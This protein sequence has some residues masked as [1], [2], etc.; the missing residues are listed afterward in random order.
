[1]TVCEE[2][3]KV[4][5][6]KLSRL[7][8]VPM[9]V[10][11]SQSLSQF[12][13]N[14]VS[15]SEVLDPS[16]SLLH[17]PEDI[18]FE[19]PVKNFLHSAK[20]GLPFLQLVCDWS[21]VKRRIER[22]ELTPTGATAR[23][24]T[25]DLV[26]DVNQELVLNDGCLDDD[27]CHLALP[28]T[29]LRKGSLTNVDFRINDERAPLLNQEESGRVAYQGLQTLASDILQPTD[30]KLRQ[31]RMA[32]W[33]IVFSENKPPLPNERVDESALAHDVDRSAEEHRHRLFSAIALIA[34]R[35]RAADPRDPS[36]KQHTNPGEGPWRE[37]VNL[38]RLK[39]PDGKIVLDDFGA[40]NNFA[41]ELLQAIENASIRR[42]ESDRA[43]K[44]IELL[45]AQLAVFSISQIIIGAVPIKHVYSLNARHPKRCVVKFAC[46]AELSRFTLEESRIPTERQK[47]Y[48]KGIPD[49]S[50]RVDRCWFPFSSR[51]SDFLPLSIPILYSTLTSRENHIEVR[52]PAGSRV[53]QVL[54]ITTPKLSWNNRPFVQEASGPEIPT[55]DADPSTISIAVNSAEKENHTEQGRNPLKRRPNHERSDSY[56]V[57]NE[58][59]HIRNPDPANSLEWIQVHLLPRIGLTPLIATAV[60]ALVVTI[61]WIYSGRSFARRDICVESLVLDLDDG[62]GF[63]AVIGVVYGALWFSSSLHPVDRRLYRITRLT[64][65]WC[66]MFSAFSVLLIFPSAGTKSVMHVIPDWRCF[67]MIV[68]LALIMTAFQLLRRSPS[69]DVDRALIITIGVIAIASG[70]AFASS[71]ARSPM[72]GISTG[73]EIALVVISAVSLYAVGWAAVYTS[74]AG[75]RTTDSEKWISTSPQ[76]WIIQR[77]APSSTE[78]GPWDCPYIDVDYLEHFTDCRSLKGYVQTLVK[79]LHPSS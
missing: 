60:N 5:S 23:H 71:A 46:D 55:S 48:A 54:A 21:W 68:T 77:S 34:S 79:E 14:G 37:P 4:T 75:Q 8:R 30:E 6:V 13:E 53:S 47:D 73:M 65:L 20:S 66:A 27:D 61:C 29:F 45:S 56:R 51:P 35:K 41:I 28:I 38:P 40:V 25:H 12:L 43:L 16:T 70:L 44:R 72:T 42:E 74:K 59:I 22:I 7:K 62:F 63:L 24:F 33:E 3:F 49:P 36:S 58:R 78:T 69:K 11:E 15:E 52:P 18:D 39:K 31:L 19:Q 50:V 57:T 2:R 32:I 67:Q 64:V 10:N 17:C 1:M 26:M 9:S 76:P